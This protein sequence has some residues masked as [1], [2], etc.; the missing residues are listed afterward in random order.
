MRDFHISEIS[1]HLMSF[2][3]F[4]EE[5]NPIAIASEI[6]LFHRSLPFCGT[7]DLVCWIPKGKDGHIWLIDYKPGMPYNTHQVQLSCYAMIWNKIFPSHKIDKVGCLYLKNGWIKAPTYTLKEYPIDEKLVR[8]V[9][10]AWK[11]YNTSPR[12]AEPTPSFKDEFPTT[13]KIKGVINNGTT[14]TKA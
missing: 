4:W 1:K 11:W 9:Y 6:Q 3:K 7:A 5:K 2:Q 12:G 8:I 10:N 14:K 13:F